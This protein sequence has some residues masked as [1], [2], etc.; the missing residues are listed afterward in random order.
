[1]PALFIIPLTIIPMVVYLILGWIFDAAGS[2][3]W[4]TEIFGLT[5]VGGRQWTFS[6]GDLMLIGGLVCLFLEVLK[7]TNS[8]SRA[9][10]NH[11]L[12]TIVFIVYLLV[13]IL[14]GI[15]AHS[16]FFMLM[17]MSAFDVIAGFSITIKTA[18]RD[19]SYSRTIDTPP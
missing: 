14:V 17:A 13:F 7:S 12:S 2:N 3:F 9:I 4:S 8:S 18:A 1:M 6:L 16:V 10:T 5:L 11:I 19:I 15:A